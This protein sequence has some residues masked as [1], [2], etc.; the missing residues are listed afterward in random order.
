MSTS[1]GQTPEAGAML[2]LQNTDRDTTMFRHTSGQSIEIQN[3]LCRVPSPE[4][5]YLFVTDPTVFQKAIFVNLV[6]GE[7]KEIA[8]DVDWEK[9]CS[10]SGWIADHSYG[11]PSVINQG[12]IY[13]IDA[14]TG[15][16]LGLVE[17]EVATELPFFSSG[18]NVRAYSP[19][20]SYVIYRRCDNSMCSGSEYVIYDVETDSV[21]GELDRHSYVGGHPVLEEELFSWSHSGQYV[22][23][24]SLN[25]AIAIYNIANRRHID[26]DFLPT[27]IANTR[28]MR[29]YSWKWSPDNSKIAFFMQNVDTLGYAFSE[30]LAV[31]DIEN[32]TFNILELPQEKWAKNLTCWGWS[33]NGN[34][35]VIVDTQNIFYEVTTDDSN[36]TQIADDVQCVNFYYHQ[37]EF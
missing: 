34:S 12:E 33:L 36:S 15:N 37:S 8:W 3:G 32:A 30:G 7:I 9:T 14:S 11:I 16:I 35:I 29:S 5:D 26:L 6:I 1:L 18:R 22:I 2:Y 28:V 17:Q 25:N 20:R 31:V 23:Y 27:N 10:S 4:L 19:D 24:R 13:Q 21:I